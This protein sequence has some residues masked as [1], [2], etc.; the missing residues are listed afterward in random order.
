M[1]PGA[2]YCRNTKGNHR[3][4]EFRKQKKQL[5]QILAQMDARIAADDILASVKKSNLNFHIQESPF[6][7]QI[8]IRK[9]YIRNKNGDEIKPS[10]DDFAVAHRT[11]IE[12]EVKLSDLRKENALLTNSLS[13]LESEL[14]KTHKAFQESSMKLE[15]AQK[16]VL[17]A[18]KSENA[19]SKKCQNIE[20]EIIQTENDNK[21]LKNEMKKLK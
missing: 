6:S 18:R 9:T 12:M 2:R 19:A 4:E 15:K 5:I 11:Y 21:L 7:V 20:E 13:I 1:K 10:N 17:D 8:N 3:S 16:D 14:Q